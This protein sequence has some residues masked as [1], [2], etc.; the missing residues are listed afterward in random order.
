ML[1]EV[2]YS[3]FL[4]LPLLLL[5]C[6]LPLMLRGMG[7]RQVE[8][9]REVDVWTT[10]ERIEKVFNN[11]NNV[12][13]KWQEEIQTVSERKPIFP[14]FGGGGP[15]IRFEVSQS[16]P[17]RLLRVADGKEGEIVF[18]LTEIENDGTSVRVSY[19]PAAKPRI[20]TLKATFPVKIFAGWQSCPSC[21]KPVLPDFVVCPYCSQKLE[22][23]KGE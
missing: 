11:L 12:V 18:E 19:A 6:L 5:C 16:I 8:A 15:Q 14:F 3:T 4:L 10:E 17:P 7:S 13:E 20:Q 9:A 22:G 21:N 23:R 2:E 1:P